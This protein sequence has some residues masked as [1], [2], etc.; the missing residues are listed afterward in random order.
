VIDYNTNSTQ[1]LAFFLNGE[2]T[3]VH[4]GAIYLKTSKICFLSHKH[5]LYCLQIKYNV[6]MFVLGL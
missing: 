1:H 6:H 2:E 4:W 5:H 3:W